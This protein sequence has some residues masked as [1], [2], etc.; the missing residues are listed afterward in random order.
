MST[1]KNLHAS[2]HQRLLNA[3]KQS[4]RPF[5]DLVMYY[6]GSRGVESAQNSRVSC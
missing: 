6:A 3:A 2:I 1:P 5:N 4:G